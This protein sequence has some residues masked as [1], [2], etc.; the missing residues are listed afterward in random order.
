MI[1]GIKRLVKN[2]PNGIDINIIGD[3]DQI[4]SKYFSYNPTDGVKQLRSSIRYLIMCFFHIRRFN[5]HID[6]TLNFSKASI[7]QEGID[8]DGVSK[9]SIVQEGSSVDDANDT[10]L[11]PVF[12]YKQLNQTTKKLPAG[13]KTCKL[14]GEKKKT[15][16]E[17]LS[18]GRDG[19]L[20]KKKVEQDRRDFHG[21]GL[22]EEHPSKKEETKRV[23]RRKDRLVG[24]HAV[25]VRSYKDK[26]LRRALHRFCK[27]GRHVHR[28]C[29]YKRADTNKREL[30]LR[31]ISVLIDPICEKPDVEGDDYVP[32]QRN[33]PCRL[34]I[35]DNDDFDEIDL[36]WMISQLTK[37]RDKFRTVTTAEG[38]DEAIFGINRPPL[39]D[40]VA[41]KKKQTQSQDNEDTSDLHEQRATNI[42]ASPTTKTDQEKIKGSFS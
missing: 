5:H 8:V 10:K 33:S 38:V 7:L 11:D 41:Y 13:K 24:Q 39:Q 18:E 9:A 36:N 37:H 12:P 26:A 35:G 17:L 3:Q 6:H 23:L 15:T 19:V 28:M 27:S 16:H 4:E 32:Q 21:K 40:I 22:A 2:H 30:R 29:R 31:H 20:Q 25:S 1:H 42:I 34:L 14:T